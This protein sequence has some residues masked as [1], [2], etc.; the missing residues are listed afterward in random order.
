[1]R[2]GLTSAKAFYNVGSCYHQLG[3]LTTAVR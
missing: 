1:M 2:E 3:K